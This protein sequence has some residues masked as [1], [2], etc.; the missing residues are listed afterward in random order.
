MSSIESYINPD[1]KIIRVSIRRN[2]KGDYIQTV[3]LESPV[4][5]DEVS[6]LSLP[7]QVIKTGQKKMK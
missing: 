5:K 2:K 4:S 1:T 3:V 6:K 7:D